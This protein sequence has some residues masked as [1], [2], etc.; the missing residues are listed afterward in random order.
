[1]SRNSENLERMQLKLKRNSENLKRMQLAL[2]RKPQKH[3]HSILS[4]EI[5]IQKQ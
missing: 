5:N 1:M 3:N 2:K 4:Q